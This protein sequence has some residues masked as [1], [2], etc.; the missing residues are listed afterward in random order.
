MESV[1]KALSTCLPELLRVARRACTFPVRVRIKRVDGERF[2]VF[3]ILDVP[4]R[5]LRAVENRVGRALLFH[6][7]DH[8]ISTALLTEASPAPRLRRR[9]RPLRKRARA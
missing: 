2:H 3:E 9:V 5:R 8:G 4:S 7:Y 6:C 1:Q